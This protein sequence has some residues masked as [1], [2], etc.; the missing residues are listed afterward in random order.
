MKCSEAQAD[1][2]NVFV[3]EINN[4]EILII[5][6][7]NSN[8]YSNLA[9]PCVTYIYEHTVYCRFFD[10]SVTHVDIVTTINF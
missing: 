4:K 7:K 1:W 10:M 9:N 5:L 8:L 3:K 6:K 2:S